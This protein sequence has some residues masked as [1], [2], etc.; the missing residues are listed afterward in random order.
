VTCISYPKMKG[1]HLESPIISAKEYLKYSKKVGRMPRVMPPSIV[2]CYSTRLIDQIRNIHEISVV[3]GIFDNVAT[4][5]Y[6]VGGTRDTVGILAEFGV[7]APATVMHM[8]ELIA[9]GAKRFVILGMAGGLN[10][11]LKPGDIVV[12][13]KSIR[14]EGTSHHYVRNSKYAFPNKDLTEALFESISTDFRK[15]YQG[16][17]WTIDAPYRETVKE[18]IHYRSEGVMTVE[19]EASAV[20]AVGQVR[21]VETAAVFVISDL[22]TEKAWKPSIQSPSV[23]R[24][25]VRAFKPINSTLAQPDL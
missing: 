19:M 1:K 8:E 12:C 23:L 2:L 20:F 14:D 18:L 13:T 22:L 9:W 3:Q 4:K 5:L 21:K 6:T 15:S 7:G 10:E 25:L 16:P 24:R 11:K 17:S